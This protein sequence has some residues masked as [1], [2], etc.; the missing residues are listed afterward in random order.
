[1]HSFKANIDIIG[2]N[3]FVF[4]PSKILKDIFKKAGTDKGSIPICGTI[5]GRAYKQTL[6]KYSGNWRLYINGIM[7]KNSPKRIGEVVE[8]TIELDLIDRTIESHPKLVKSLAEDSE[9]K[10]IFDDLPA[11]KQKEIVR[12]ISSLKTEKSID[13]NVNRAIALYPTD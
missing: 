9:A 1:M 8:I 7:L 4:V 3:P 2:I 10:R 13:K 11:S 12:Y 5:N 6:V